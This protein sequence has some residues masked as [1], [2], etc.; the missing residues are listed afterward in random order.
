MVVENLKDVRF[1]DFNHFN[2]FDEVLLVLHS[3]TSDGG[4][5]VSTNEVINGVLK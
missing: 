1:L 3:S 2:G 5:T 4:R